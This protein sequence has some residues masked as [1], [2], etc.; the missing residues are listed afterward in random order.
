MN[1]GMRWLVIAVHGFLV[2]LRS[3]LHRAARGAPDGRGKQGRRWNLGPLLCNAIWEMSTGMHS[4]RAVEILTEVAEGGKVGTFGGR[5]M[6]DNTLHGL[7]KV[8]REDTVN[9]CGRSVGRR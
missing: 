6:P 3:D 2:K 9:W 7:L 4:L 5:R 8:T 1:N